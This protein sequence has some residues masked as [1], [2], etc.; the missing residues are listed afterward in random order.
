MYPTFTVFRS[1][2]TDM[3]NINAYNRLRMPK[4]AIKNGQYR[5]STEI[6]NIGYKRRRK[7]KQN[8]QTNTN[9]VYKKCSLLQTTGGNTCFNNSPQHNLFSLI[10]LNT[11]NKGDLCIT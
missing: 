6:G 8:T 3:H 11:P 5:E 9:D 2:F 7:T 4:G 1:V 10:P